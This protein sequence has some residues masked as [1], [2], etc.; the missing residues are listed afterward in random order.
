MPHGNI[1]F[2]KDFDVKFILLN[3]IIP[4]HLCYL[5]LFIH[6]CS[7]CGFI[8]L[9]LLKANLYY[10]ACS[11]NNTKQHTISCLLAFFHNNTKK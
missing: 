2:F 7:I 6:A 5:A 9:L 1:R 11:Q 10:L 8:L 4:C 3:L